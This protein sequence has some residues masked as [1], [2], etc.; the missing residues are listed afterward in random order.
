[1]STSSSDLLAAVGIAAS[2]EDVKALSDEQLWERLTE[3]SAE[4]KLAYEEPDTKGAVKG[5]ATRKVSKFL[6][7]LEER[8]IEVNRTEWIP[9]TSVEAMTAEEL[10]ALL[11]ESVAERQAAYDNPE[12]RGADKSTA[13]KKVGSVLETLIERGQTIEEIKGFL[14]DPDAEVPESAREPAEEAEDEESTDES[15][16]T[17]QPASEPQTPPRQRRPRPTPQGGAPA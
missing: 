7:A 2:K 6:D 15:A 1:M 13:T 16:Q 14:A 9:E 8:G 5:A 4:R 3:A 17:S 10:Y 12:S 11:R